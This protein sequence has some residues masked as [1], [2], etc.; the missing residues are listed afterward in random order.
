M[1]VFAGIALVVLSSASS[2]KC[3]FESHELSGRVLN[4]AGQP[5]A[6]VEVTAS[7][8]ERGKAVAISS[9]S[10]AN[11]RYAI[12]VQFNHYSGAGF[13]GR[14]LCRGKLASIRV[15]AKAADYSEASL[16][17]SPDAPL[18]TLDFV[19]LVHSND[20]G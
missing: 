4:T 15:V 3:I 7:W 12:T 19:L 1:R 16:E 17:V 6:G 14:D 9:A 2:A 5:I 20:D 10:D 18:E 13:L 11:G 8:L